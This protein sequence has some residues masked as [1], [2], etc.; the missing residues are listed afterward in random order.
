[1]QIV[2]THS[3][4]SDRLI[5]L[6]AG[7]GM[8]AHPLRKLTHRDYDI[9]VAFDYR[10]LTSDNIDLLDNYREICVIAWSFGV[11]AANAFLAGRPDLPVT[12]RIAVNGTLHPVDDLRGI[13][14]A[15]FEGTLNGLSAATLTKFQRRMC[16]SAALFAEFKEQAPERTDISELADELRAIDRLPEVPESDLRLWDTIYISDADRIIPAE[17]QHRA[18]E[19]HRHIV[20]LPGSHLPDFATLLRNAIVSKPLIATRFS[21]SAESYIATAEAQRTI[22]RRLFEL[23]ERESPKPDDI[24]EIGCGTGFLT[25]LIAERYAGASLMLWDIANIPADLPGTHRQYDAETEIRQLPERSVDLIASAST[26]QWFNSPATFIRNCRRAVRDSGLLALSTFGPDHFDELQPYLDS[27]LHYPTSESWR[28]MLQSAGFKV[29][30][31]SEE[32]IEMKFTDTASLLR[33]ISKTG[34]N[35]LPS[36]PASTSIMRSLLNSGI[37]TLTYHAVYLIAEPD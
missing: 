22:A 36:G 9:A 12:A 10:N 13:P 35:A 14:R 8:D 34:V 17:N 25:R 1:M 23:I 32:R 3:T 29:I 20:G 6:F 30:T 4:Q 11:P 15:I 33:H 37:D 7:W 21:R 26:I 18:W 24:L 27:T 2:L 5:L 19:G 28:Q 31:I 16:G